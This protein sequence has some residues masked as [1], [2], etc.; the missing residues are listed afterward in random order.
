V[1]YRQV[2]LD[3]WVLERLKDRM[4]RASIVASRTGRPVV[5]YR[6]TIEEIDSAA[7]EE[8]A[9]I[10]EQYVVVQVLT[11]G[12]FIPPDL[13]QQRVFTYDQ[14]ADWIMNRSRDLLMQCIENLDQEIS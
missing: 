8:I 3:D 11:H 4:R 10:N 12:G 13:A 2:T 14:F 6:N 5:L 7:E 1:A 9:T